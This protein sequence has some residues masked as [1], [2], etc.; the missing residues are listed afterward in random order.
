ALDGADDTRFERRLV[1]QVAECLEE[2]ALQLPLPP[3]Q[4]VRRLQ[5][6]HRSATGFERLTRLRIQVSGEH[7]AWRAAVRTGFQDGQALVGRSREGHEQTG[8]ENQGSHRSF[9]SWLLAP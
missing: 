6:S 2:L 5:G 1:G 3:R 8:D 9:P 4:V 7:R